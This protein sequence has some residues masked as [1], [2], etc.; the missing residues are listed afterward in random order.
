MKK[1][2]ATYII[3]CNPASGAMCGQPE[4]EVVR[5]SD[6]GNVI[7]KDSFNDMFD[8]CKDLTESDVLQ[9]PEGSVR[10]CTTENGL[11]I[12]DDEEYQ[13]MRYDIHEIDL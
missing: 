13:V 4:A 7:L 11:N 3:D 1:Y 8:Y 12:L 6:T 2:F 5:Y 10:V 9:W